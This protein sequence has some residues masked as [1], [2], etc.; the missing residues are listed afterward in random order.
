MQKLNDAT[1]KIWS[2]LVDWP[3]RYLSLKVGMTT[4]DGW[5]ANHWYTISSPCT[6]SAQVS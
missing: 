5:T 6:P 4:T 1:Y 2:R 3:Q